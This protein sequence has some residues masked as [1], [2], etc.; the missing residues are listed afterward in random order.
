MLAHIFF[1]PREKVR[2]ILFSHFGLFD[3]IWDLYITIAG[4]RDSLVLGKCL[5]L[6]SI[7]L[8]DLGVK[9]SKMVRNVSQ[10]FPFLPIFF[11]VCFCFRLQWIGVDNYKPALLTLKQMGKAP[12]V[13]VMSEVL[14]QTSVKVV[15]SVTRV[16]NSYVQIGA[17]E[18]LPVFAFL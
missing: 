5:D 6:S 7:S 9:N 18:M 14:V 16:Y 4:K 12:S 11:H 3:P 15:E 13:E 17:D 1:F 10:K 8:A 2:E